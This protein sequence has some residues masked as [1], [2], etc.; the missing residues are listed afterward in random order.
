[1]GVAKRNDPSGRTYNRAFSVWLQENGFD[2]IDSGNRTRLLQ[3]MDTLDAIEAWR[4]DPAHPE[5]LRL[6]Y[7][8]ALWRAWRKD[9]DGDTPRRPQTEA[10]NAARKAHV[11][12][13]TIL[14]P[15]ERRAEL[16]AFAEALKIEDGAGRN[17][18]PKTLDL[19]CSDP[20]KRRVALERLLER[21]EVDDFLVI[22]PP[23][24]RRGLEKHV[25]GLHGLTRSDQITKLL[26]RA[27]SSRSPAE[28]ITA[29][30]KANEMLAADG[31]SAADLHAR[32]PKAKR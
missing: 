10:L 32:V 20:E 13:T 19:W 23:H 11:N 26:H 24:L 25:L 12:R 28:Q 5:R 22:V 7:P 14:T 1:M 30:A 27:L 31:F 6:N 18:P 3:L 2:D 17:V 16:H 21:V 9:I 15:G 4:A 8:S 29:L